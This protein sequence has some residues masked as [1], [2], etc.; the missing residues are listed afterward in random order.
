MEVCSPLCCC[1]CETT[2]DYKKLREAKKGQQF[3]LGLN[4][5]F[6]RLRSQILSM[7]PTPSLSKIFSLTLQEEQ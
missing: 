3:L 6:D 2:K 1:K 4:E 5:N 7:E